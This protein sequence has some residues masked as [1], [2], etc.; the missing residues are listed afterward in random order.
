[1]MVAII[2]LIVT[3]R[4][5]TDG[6]RPFARP[7]A[8]SWIGVLGYRARPEQAGEPAAPAGIDINGGAHAGPQPPQVLTGRESMRI[9]TRWTIL[10]QLPAAF[11]GGRMETAP[12]CRG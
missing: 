3:S 1:M 4:R 10:I 2:T 8:R 5:C 12:P 11:C 9:G 6:V 7:A